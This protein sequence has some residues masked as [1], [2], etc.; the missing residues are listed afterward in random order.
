M[1]N[2]FI[3]LLVFTDIVMSLGF[4]VMRK[5]IEELEDRVKTCENYNKLDEKEIRE[6]RGRCRA[7][8]DFLRNNLCDLR[9]GVK[10]LAEEIKEEKSNG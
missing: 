2:A 7:I 9:D 8:E 5:T 3:V 6:L 10:V 1:S 4:F